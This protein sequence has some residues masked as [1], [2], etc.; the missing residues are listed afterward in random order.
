MCDCV[1]KRER[2]DPRPFTMKPVLKRVGIVESHEPGWT[3]GQHFMRLLAHVLDDACRAPGVELLVLTDRVPKTGERHILEDK[4][5]IVMVTPR[6]HI[7]GKKF[8]R[9]LLQLPD[10][11]DLLKTA[12]EN[13]VDVL[14]PLLSIPDDT[15]GLKTI[16]WIPDFQHLHLPDCF[17]EADRQ[18]RDVRFRLLAERASLVMLTSQD[19]RKDFTAFVPERAHKARVVSFPASIAPKT[20][21]DDPAVT[22]RKFNLP[23][24]FALVANQFWR[25]KNHKVVVEAIARLRRKNVRIPVVM[26][27]LPADYRDPANQVLSQ[28]LQA[29]ACA[30]LGDQVVLLGFVPEG[31]VIALMRAAALVIQPSRFEG[32]STVVQNTKAL[33]RPIVCSD[34]AAHREQAPHALAF[35]PCESAEA[36]ADILATCWPQLESGPDLEMERKTLAAER[37]AV[38][39]YGQSILKLCRE[40]SSL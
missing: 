19:A 11:S 26:T 9:G 34:I 7:R 23:E 24:K 1:A 12:R 27:G 21:A 2:L 20:I 28:T 13:K 40:A 31:D 32:W 17:S 16:G 6:N 37:E 14:L 29:I 25:H 30:G 3:G 38:K 15:A 22:V 33:G 36:L 35:F 10:R 39:Q 5:R 18:A 4:K 8:L